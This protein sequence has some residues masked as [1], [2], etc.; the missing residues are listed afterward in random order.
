M[1]GVKDMALDEN[2]KRAI[3]DVFGEDILKQLDEAGKAIA[4]MGTAYKDFS[5]VTELNDEGTDS[6]KEAAAFKALLPDL[7]EGQNEVVEVAT[8]A[9]KAVK[10]LREQ[11]TA[12]NEQIAA[13]KEQLDASPRRASQAKETEIDSSAL[14]DDVRETMKTR[15]PFWGTVVDEV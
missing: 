13:M 7:I 2:K 1:Q 9:I 6:S 15:D 5:P 14:P 12:Q 4:D 8:E 3:A 10:E 11:I